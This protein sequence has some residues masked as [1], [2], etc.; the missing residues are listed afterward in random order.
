MSAAQKMQGR[1]SAP[2][3][4]AE[5]LDEIEDAEFEMQ[6]DVWWPVSAW[7]ADS[8]DP[9]VK[10]VDRVVPLHAE[11]ARRSLTFAT[12]RRHAIAR[13]EALELLCLTVVQVMLEANRIQEET[14]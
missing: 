10:H 13:R 3:P 6:N 2:R 7:A 5:L 12:R 8:L 11:I 4:I 14:P 9:I 1:N